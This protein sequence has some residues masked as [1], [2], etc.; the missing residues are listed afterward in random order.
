M[1]SARK[2][3]F[4]V[5]NQTV[6]G[7][8]SK[9]LALIRDTVSDAG[10]SMADKLARE[11]WHLDKKVPLALI[12]AIAVQTGTA[13][14]WV[15]AKNSDDTHRDERLARIESVQDKAGETQ[16]KILEQLARL[17]E[18]VANQT[19]VLRDIRDLVGRAADHPG[20][21]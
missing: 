15:S 6:G 11:G 2:L 21:K 1:V 10:C 19:Q 4:G 5:E 18:R 16:A 9:R 8:F 13:V 3:Q 20:G 12:F 14:W 7:Q 17:D